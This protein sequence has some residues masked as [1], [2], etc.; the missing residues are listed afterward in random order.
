MPTPEDVV[1]LSESTRD[2]I[3]E[4]THFGAVA[5]CQADGRLLAAAGNPEVVQYWRSASKPLQA[6][7]VVTSGA[8]DRFGLSPRELAQCCAS[9]S[10]SAL[11][12]ETVR[13]ILAKIGLDESYLQCGVHAPGDAAERAR[14]AQAGEQP[15]AIH[16]NCSGKHAGMLATCLALGADP[17]S[18]L[19]REHP[20][21]RLI[22]E[23]LAI[24]SDTP[25]ASLHFGHDG[26]DAPTA[27]QTLRAQALAWARLAD[28]G[29]LPAE[30]AAAAQRVA[31]AICT[32]PE[33]LSSVGS[34]SA[35]LIAAGQG[36][37]IC[38]SGAAGLFC[39]GLRGRGVGVAFKM[40][41]GD[42]GT[43]P[44]VALE[45]LQRLGVELPQ[46]LID[47]FSSIPVTNCRGRLVGQTRAAQFQL[48]Q[49]A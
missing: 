8:A 38:K 13:G 11:H 23:H 39:I 35:R 1:A 12:I 16:N 40:A 29:G 49:M 46:A 3:A 14:L 4:V 19:E 9:H 42:G 2:G 32:A 26:C 36:E 48:R 31:D 47:E 44:Q 25:V 20:V 28:P 17:G 15:T 10:G 24:M 22:A 18:Y 6:L 21:Q 30:L 37:I 7:S 34:F 43:H 45:L 41:D 33:L 5:I 27:A